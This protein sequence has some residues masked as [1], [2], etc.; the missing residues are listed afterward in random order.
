MLLKFYLIRKRYKLR[1]D[2]VRV[3]KW[4]SFG[5]REK[6]LSCSFVYVITCDFVNFLF[7]STGAEIFFICIGQLSFYI[8]YSGF[9]LSVVKSKPK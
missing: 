7:E 3:I 8:V 4:K 5:G 1:S 9:H 6:T 2:V